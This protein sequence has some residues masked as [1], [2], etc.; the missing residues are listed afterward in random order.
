MPTIRI[1]GPDVAQVLD[2]VSEGVFVQDVKP[3][4]KLFEKGVR[5]RFCILAPDPFSMTP[6]RTYLLQGLTPWI[7]LNP[8]M[9]TPETSD[10]TSI[11]QRVDHV[12]AQGKTAELAAAEGAASRARVRRSAWK[13]ISG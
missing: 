2:N 9:K 13:S 3:N 8:W 7:G 10:Y 4:V 12:E 11:K 5:S 1:L 6:F